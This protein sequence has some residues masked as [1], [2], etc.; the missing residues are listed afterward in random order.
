[1]PE[2]IERHYFRNGNQTYYREGRV[3]EYAPLVRSRSEIDEI[4]YISE[5]AMD[6]MDGP[7]PEDRR[8]KDWKPLS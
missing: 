1:M 6:L 4:D 2:R 5:I 3:Y 8:P 7:D